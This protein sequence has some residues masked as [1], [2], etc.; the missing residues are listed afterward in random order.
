MSANVEYFA[1]VDPSDPGR[2]TYWRS[3]KRGLKPW[4]AQARYGPVLYRSDV[5]ADLSGTA[6][7]E[8]I[9]TWFAERS[10]PWHQAIREAIATDPDDCRARF[11]AFTSHCC[12]CGR[13]LT[14]PASKTYGIGPECRTGISSTTLARLAELVARAHALAV[15]S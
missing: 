4:P 2:M 13:G 1:V 11:A 5:P 9:A 15:R 6:R 10:Q 8:W 14:D 12:M 3:G 7:R